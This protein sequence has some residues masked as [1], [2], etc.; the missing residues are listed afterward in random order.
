MS[1]KSLIRRVDL[2]NLP[3]NRVLGFPLKLELGPGKLNLGYS[4]DR[5]L[6]SEILLLYLPVL[7]EDDGP[8]GVHQRIEPRKLA[9]HEPCAETEG[10]GEEQEGKVGLEEGKIKGDLLAKLVADLVDIAVVQEVLGA[11]LLD[12]RLVERVV[13][14]REDG[15]DKLPLAPLGSYARAAFI[16]GFGYEEVCQP[17]PL[18]FRHGLNAKVLIQ[19]LVRSNRPNPVKP[20]LDS[21]P[22]G[23]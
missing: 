16:L 13:V 5:P 3:S 19:V 6:N 15:G 7:E 4:S 18:G 2:D 22:V 9:Q 1:G 23:L 8:Q 10:G 14:Q 21:I 17:Q 11:P 12:P 20:V